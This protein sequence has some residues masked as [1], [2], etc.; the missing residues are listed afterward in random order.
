[1]LLQVSLV[2]IWS[3]WKQLVTNCHAFEIY[4]YVG[5]AF[6]RHLLF[7]DVIYIPTMRQSFRSQLKL[8]T[9]TIFYTRKQVVQHYL[10][11]VVGPYSVL[12]DIEKN[13]MT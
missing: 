7:S 5:V 1:M 11:N 13:P 3:K 4:I 2:A 12:S 9:V 6:E 10:L 8:A